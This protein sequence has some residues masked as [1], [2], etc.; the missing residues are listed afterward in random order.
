MNSGQSA[1]SLGIPTLGSALPGVEAS[2]AD[3]EVELSR[4]L[5]DSLHKSH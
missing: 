4:S 2:E 5:L 1:V 3:D